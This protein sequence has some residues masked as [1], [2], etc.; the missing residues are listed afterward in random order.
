MSKFMPRP[1]S[2]TMA[3][4]LAGF[5]G[6]GGSA[7]ATEDAAAV[8]NPV[9]RQQEVEKVSLSSADHKKFKILD[10]EFKTGPEVTR[11][12]LSCHTEASLQLHKTY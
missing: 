5:G 2:V 9:A 4:L 6:S 8:T 10:Q 12:C 7:C 11:A 3:L 1:V